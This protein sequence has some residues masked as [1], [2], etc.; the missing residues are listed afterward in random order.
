M[1]ETSGL[2][3]EAPNGQAKRN[4]EKLALDKRIP[5][6]GGLALF[7]FAISRKHRFGNRIRNRFF[8]AFGKCAGAA[9]RKVVQQDR[10][11]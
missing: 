2:A 9:A 11:D 1:Y 8:G 10:K 6:Y 4:S 3:G 7:S 5:L